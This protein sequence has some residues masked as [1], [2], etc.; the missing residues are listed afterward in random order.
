[1]SI[2]S[3]RLN[4]IISARGYQ[5]KKLAAD[6]KLSPARLNNYVKGVSEPNFEVLASLCGY[7]NVTADYLIGLS[8]T[9]RPQLIQSEADLPRPD[10]L[11]CQP[12]VDPL[13]KLHHEYRDKAVSYIDYLHQ[14]QLNDLLG[15]GKEA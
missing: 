13:A 1:M 11:H 15:S 10:L 6:L 3:D 12:F 5:Q 4:S 7:L 2:F 14:Q 8:D 9:P